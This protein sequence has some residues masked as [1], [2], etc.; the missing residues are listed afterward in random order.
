MHAGRPRTYGV[1]GVLPALVHETAIG[2]ALVLDEAVAIAIPVMQH[3]LQRSIGMRKQIV[4]DIASQT[5][6]SQ[7]PSSI[8]NSGVASIVPVDAAAAE[9]ERGIHA[10]A[11]LVQDAT[12]LLLGK[13]GS[14]RI[15]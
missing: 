7:L 3:P 1:P 4:D 10:E 9:G 13:R 12:G 8:T 15:P 11:H 6:A 5:P 2:A 14:L